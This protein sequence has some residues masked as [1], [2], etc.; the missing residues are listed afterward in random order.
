MP[1][2]PRFLSLLSLRLALLLGVG[3]AAVL[4]PPPRS[5]LWLPS[6]RSALRLG[7]GR[8]AVPCPPRRAYCSCCP[9][10]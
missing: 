2:P 3:R 4:R 8:A 7:V 6:L 5:P 1:P 9:C 10:A